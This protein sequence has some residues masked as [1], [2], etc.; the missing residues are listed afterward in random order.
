MR[1]RENLT[2]RRGG[3]VPQ[4]SHWVFRLGLT[5]DVAEAH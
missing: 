2:R 5:T 3:N 4:Q 1:P